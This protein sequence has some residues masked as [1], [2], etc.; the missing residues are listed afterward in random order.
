MEK[1]YLDPPSVFL[2]G[3]KSRSYFALQLKSETPNYISSFSPHFFSLN[4]VGCAAVSCW[5][6]V[7]GIL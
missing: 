6:R 2:V 1:G 4:V 3:G 7:S 5:E